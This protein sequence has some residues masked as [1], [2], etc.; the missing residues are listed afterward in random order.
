MP[1]A[2]SVPTCFL[3]LLALAAGT[4][5]SPRSSADEP[6]SAKEGEWEPVLSD[7]EQR[8]YDGDLARFERRYQAM[9]DPQQVFELLNE[10]EAQGTRAARD[11]LIQLARK[12]KSA[13]YRRRAFEILVKIGGKPSLDLLCG[14]H[15]LRSGDFNVQTQAATALERTTD[16]RCVP[17]LLELLAGP[18][19]KMETLGQVCLTVGRVGHDDP[20]VEEALFKR[21]GEKRD[22][23]RARVL[24]ALGNVR[25]EK[26][27]QHVHQ[28]LQKEKNATARAGAA[29]GLG[30]AGRQD[31]V[32][33][34]KAVVA[35]DN[36]QPVREAALEALK[37][38]GAK[39][40]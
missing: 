20:K 18:A 36:A 15:G 40:D 27:F 2:R 37:A 12:V 17:V 9:E 14:K 8:A 29:R 39:P 35:K 32:P 34:L 23:V 21:V 30:H 22:T 10:L 24:E 19:L 5:A 33:A 1:H 38:L 31:A 7:E 16:K 26:A 6:P 25:T 13:E 28:A 4:A 3:A 11:W